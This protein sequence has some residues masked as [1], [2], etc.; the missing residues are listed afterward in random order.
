[1][2]HVNN[3]KRETINDGENGTAKLRKN[4]NARWKGNLQ[5]LGNIGNELDKKIG[6]ERK[7]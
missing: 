3:E 1:M 7:N 2:R 4:Q 6:D 5:E